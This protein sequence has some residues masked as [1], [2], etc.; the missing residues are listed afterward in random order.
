[1]KGQRETFIDHRGCVEV[2]PIPAELKEGRRAGDRKESVLKESCP[3]WFVCSFVYVHVCVYSRRSSL[4]C[5]FSLVSCGISS[6]LRDLKEGW[7]QPFIY[8]DCTG[9]KALFAALPT[10]LPLIFPLTDRQMPA[11]TQPPPLR[12]VITTCTAD[13]F[14][15]GPFPRTLASPQ[16]TVLYCIVCRL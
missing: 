14:T 9:S 8:E 3:R 2:E 12:A 16:S 10:R 7:G 5:V 13:I 1:M 15:Y 6:R 11:V 4:R